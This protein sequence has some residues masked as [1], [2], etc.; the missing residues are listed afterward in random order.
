MGIGALEKE[1]TPEKLNPPEVP[2][3]YRA[4]LSLPLFSGECFVVVLL[5]DFVLICVVVDLLFCFAWVYLVSS[6][7]IV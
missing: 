6:L 4:F 3:G 7:Y 1:P 5:V 2:E